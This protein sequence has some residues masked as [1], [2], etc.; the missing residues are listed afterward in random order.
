MEDSGVGTKET[1]V[2]RKRYLMTVIFLL[3]VF[4]TNLYAVKKSTGGPFSFIVLGHVLGH[5]DGRVNPLLDELI[6]RVRK[7]YP[8]MVF[9]TGDMIWGSIMKSLVDPELVTEDWDRLDAKLD[10]LG[11]PIYRVPGNHDITYP[12]TRDIFFSRYGDL[13]RAI[14]Y[15][16]S[17]F[18]LLNS[19][20]VPQG[21][22]QAPYE[23]FRG[24][25][26]DSKQID[27]I[28]QELSEDEAYDH[29]FLF[30]H[31]LLWW[32]EDSSWW[33]DVHPLLIGR[34]VRAVFG[35]DFGPMKFSHMRR[36]GIDYIQSCIEDTFSIDNPKSLPQLRNH[37][38]SRR[39]AQQFDNFLYVTVNGPQVTIEVKTIGAISSG[40]FS[41]QRFR[42][43]HGPVGHNPPKRPKKAL[44]KR[45]W[46]ILIGTPRLLV[47]LS[48]LTGVSFLGGM[49]ATLLLK[50]RKPK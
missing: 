12:V 5:K 28:R 21:D 18:I 8:A 45:V 7:L 16:G 36:D 34:N 48:L 41:P 20:A 3:T 32:N 40:K 1:V 10:Q 30:M 14:T 37:A 22:R 33:R 47:G 4:P 11:L 31:H 9:L 17:R 39:V 43:I 25:Q 26:L 38:D 24:K 50:R 2:M 15:R 44:V 6:I 35:G 29:V 42:L 27:F 46:A 19:S 23:Y 13:P 49:A